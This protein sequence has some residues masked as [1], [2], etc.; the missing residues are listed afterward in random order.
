MEPETNPRAG[1]NDIYN[2]NRH[3]VSGLLHRVSV[4]FVKNLRVQNEAREQILHALPMVPG[5]KKVKI[6]A[7]VAATVTLKKWFQILATDRSFSEPGQI[8]VVI[9]RPRHTLKT[10]IVQVKC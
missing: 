3:P 2:L 5:R 10:R 4:F 8:K 6:G 1:N 9:A 7:L